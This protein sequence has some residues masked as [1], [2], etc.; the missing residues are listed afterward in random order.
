ML[1]NRTLRRVVAVASIGTLATSGAASADSASDE[2]ALRLGFEYAGEMWRA[3]DGGL[4]TGSSYLDKLDLTLELDAERVLGLPFTVFAHGVYNNGHSISAL[5]GDAQGVSGI[6]S[7]EALRLLEF[8][9]EWRFGGESRHTMRYGLYDVNTEFDVVPSAGLLLG[10]SHGMGREF[11]QSGEH[12]PSTFPV[13]SLALRYRW[14]VNDAWSVQ[15]AALDGVPGDPEHP[16]RSTIR[17]AKAEGALLIGEIARESSRLSKLALG[18]WQYTAEF[19]DL[20]AVDANGDPVRRRTNRGVYALADA[21]LI[22]AQGGAGSGADPRLSAFV[23][24]GA[25]N[26]DLNRFDQY[27]GAGIVLRGL[28][29]AE[30]ED[31][32]GLAVSRARNGAAYRHVNAQL[33]ESTDRTE[34]NIELTWRAR[35]NRWLTLQPDVQYVINPGTNPAVRN[36]WV[37]GLRFNIEMTRD[38]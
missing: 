12:G 32:L 8:W 11:S 20:T 36:A 37:V 2:G 10:S 24:V 23:R 35:V 26:G 27:I 22:E 9:T 30:A 13:T 16:E 33:G 25:A 21:A 4:A 3:V 19:D 18:V 34:T 5:V 14:Q 15:A 28:L 17:L 1:P 31:E 38:W 6:E 29:G 7:V